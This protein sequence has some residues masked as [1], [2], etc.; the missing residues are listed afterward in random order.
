MQNL[1]NPLASEH[2]TEAP[3]D[4][5]CF[6]HTSLLS[7]TTRPVHPNTEAKND[8]YL[9]HYGATTTHQINSTM[10][11][12]SIGIRRYAHKLIIPLLL[13]FLYP[14]CACANDNLN[15]TPPTQS[16]YDFLDYEVF[17]LE[18]AV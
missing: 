16:L 14:L 12:S 17:P 18:H 13:I 6:R 3:A 7:D 2:P 5:H 10:K 9:Q 8:F 1:L 15:P 11:N 4:S